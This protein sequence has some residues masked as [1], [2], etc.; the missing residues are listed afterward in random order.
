MGQAGNVWTDQPPARSSANSLVRRL[1]VTVMTRLLDLVRGWE[2]PGRR[3]LPALTGRAS[4]L[5]LGRLA[6][7][8]QQSQVGPCRLQTPSPVAQRG[9][10]LAAVFGL[11][12]T[13]TN[14]ASSRAASETI[15][16]S[17][18]NSARRTLSRLGV[19]R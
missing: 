11:Q 17:A 10:P 5:P 4:Q 6:E 13:Y 18:R 7:P 3:R 1:L 15:S 8:F 19:G 9:S 12:A 14:S 2:T 16:I